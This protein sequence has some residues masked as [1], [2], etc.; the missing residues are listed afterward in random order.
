M[1]CAAFVSGALSSGAARRA[2]V[3]AP[4]TLLAHWERELAACGA[5]ARTFRFYGSNEGARA[6]ALRELT[7]PR[8]GVLLTTYGMV[9]HNADA[10]SKGLG[11]VADDERPVG[12]AAAAAA[13]E[14]AGEGGGGGGGSGGGQRLLP[15]DYLIL[16][17]GHKVRWG[18]GGAKCWVSFAA[19]SVAAVWRA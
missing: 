19:Y 17:E 13:A 18:V 6:A 9:L 1:Q 14:G 7:S 5:R 10:L 12:A 2:L 3:V 16:D 4:K 11:R 8:G 15:W